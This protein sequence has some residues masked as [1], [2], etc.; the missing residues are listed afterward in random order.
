MIVLLDNEILS[1]LIKLMDK[2]QNALNL[3]DA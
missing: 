2:V 1:K 3:T